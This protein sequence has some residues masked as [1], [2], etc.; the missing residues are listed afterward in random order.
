MRTPSPEPS[1][2]G[3]YTRG[4]P[5]P[6]PPPRPAGAN[7]RTASGV[8][9]T[10]GGR[11]VGVTKSSAGPSYACRRVFVGSFEEE[12]E[13]EDEEVVAEEEEEEEE[14]EEA[15]EAA[16][17]A[18]APALAA[19][20]AAFDAAAAAAPPPRTAAASAACRAARVIPSTSLP[21]VAR[22]RASCACRR[23]AS[24]AVC[25][26]AASAMP[27]RSASA[28]ARLASVARFSSAA[29]AACL[30]AAATAACAS[31]NA[32]PACS[33]TAAADADASA[34]ASSALASNQWSSFFSLVPPITHHH[35]VLFENV[36]ELYVYI[37]ISVF[38]FFFSYG[39]PPVENEKKEKQPTNERST[40]QPPLQRLG[41]QGDGTRESL[42]GFEALTRGKGPSIHTHTHTPYRRIR[43]CLFMEYPAHR[44]GFV[45]K[46]AALTRRRPFLSRTANGLKQWCVPPFEPHAR[47]SRTN[48]VRIVPP[49]EQ[50]PRIIHTHLKFHA[51]WYLTKPVGPAP[52]RANG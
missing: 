38:F 14:E 37:R 51:N 15:V 46:P 7:N 23:A 31:A 29:A 50:P 5:P 10:P 6:P 20:P 49:S 43:D 19:A 16:L 40:G 36:V 41:S 17:A 48:R 13:E 25:A 11:G 12:E 4:A 24:A 26:A 3:K 35:H 1:N 28:A 33:D 32:L 9:T 2:P 8:S 30:S 42:E 27:A 18:L 21:A 34:F 45:M 52:R 44:G 47:A 22:L 39:S